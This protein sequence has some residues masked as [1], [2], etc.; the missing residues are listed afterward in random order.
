MS[1]ERLPKLIYEW[2]REMENGK[3]Y[4]DYTKKLLYELCLGEYWENQ[5]TT[6]TKS[7]WDEMIEERI[8]IK[9][10]LLM[11]EKSKQQ[12]EIENINKT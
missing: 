12:T 5:Q 7:E 6:E 4:M 3:G 11:D 8:H 2:E 1:T 10:K 9:K